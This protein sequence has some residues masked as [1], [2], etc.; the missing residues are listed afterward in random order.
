MGTNRKKWLPAVL[1]VVLIAVIGTTL[2]LVLPRLTKGRRQISLLEA[3]GTVQ[4]ERGD[5]T[6]NGQTDMALRTGDVLVLGENSSAR[7]RL[8]DDKFLYLGAQSRVQLTADGT[9]DSSRTLVTVEKGS[10]MTEVKRKL[11]AASTFNVVTPN[12]N[13][14]IRGTKTLTEVFEDVL[15]AIKTSAAVIEGQVSFKTVQTDATGKAAVAAVNLSVGQGMS[16]ATDARSLLSREDVA[17]IAELGKAVDGTAVPETTHEELG[18]KLEK[19][20]FSEDFLTNV[21][22]VLARSREEDVEEGFAAENVTEEELNAAINV[23][24]D[25]IDG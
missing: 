19:P 7:V 24:N 4:V 17:R 12:S 16:I 21:V 8:D 11:S 2:L 5:K 14:A 1:C 15:G 6:L 10:V 18:A 3:E 23:L 22:A 25:V 9:A 13:M 20:A